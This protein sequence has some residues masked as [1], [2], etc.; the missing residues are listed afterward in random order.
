MHA[1]G[2]DMLK[3]HELPPGTPI[4]VFSLGQLG[5]SLVTLPAVH[6]IREAFPDSEMILIS[7]RVPGNQYLLSWEVFRLSGVFSRALYYTAMNRSFFSSLLELSGTACK[8]RRSGSGPLFYLI[9]DGAKSAMVG[10]HTFFFETIC[11]T[12]M[13]G[14]SN[15]LNPYFMK[16]DDGRLLPQQ[17][18]YR[19]LFDVVQSNID[20]TLNFKTDSLIQPDESAE[21]FA[22]HLMQ[23]RFDR[24][25]V[26]FGAWSKMPCKR[27]PLD[28][29]AE[30]GRFCMT[31][32]NMI[33]LVLGG[34]NE[35]SVGAELIKEWDGEGI[36]LCGIS[37]SES[38]E[39][40]RRCK[41][42][43]GNDTGT[44]HLAAT[45]GIP[46]IGVFSSRDAPGRWDPIGR[47]H[48]IL[49][50]WVPCEGCMLEVCKHAETLCLKGIT[51]DEVIEG[52]ISLFS[53]NSVSGR[54]LS[55]RL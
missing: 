43:I 9:N 14:A 52:V 42:Y 35:Q 34:A 51:V 40:L 23:S 16:G 54:K 29:F 26:A 27:W 28:R 41:L 19:R 32:R 15:A 8:I 24:D 4:Y 45:M 3:P 18:Q 31:E 7:D 36:N 39:V 13:V 37:L 12:H 5:D 46:C 17:P 21:N 50:H 47:D 22:E 11:G 53:D 44:M 30:V 6:G 49:R 33:P 38:A 25:F 1:H 55:V 48:V 20:R 2:T 10:R